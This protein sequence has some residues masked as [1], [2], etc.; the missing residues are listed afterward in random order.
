MEYEY[1]ALTKCITA[2]DAARRLGVTKMAV[3]KRI[4]DKRMAALAIV[5]ESS[6][7]TSYAVPEWSV[8]LILLE[9]ELEALREKSAN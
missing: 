1:D 6:G 9:R 4:A 5:H 3:S 7:Y 8:R 2:A